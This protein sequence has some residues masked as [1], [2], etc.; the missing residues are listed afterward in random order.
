MR[1]L[2]LRLPLSLIGGPDVSC[3][4]FSELEVLIMFPSV[5]LV[6]SEGAEDKS[7]NVK[8]E[9]FEDEEDEVKKEN[10]KGEEKVNLKKKSTYD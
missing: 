9:Y 6:K 4:S 5:A 10:I 3:Q 8:E 7:V 2:N 1:R